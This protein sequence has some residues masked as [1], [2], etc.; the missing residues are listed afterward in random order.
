MPPKNGMRPIHPGELL[1]DELV[2]L[3]TS[4]DEFDEL[5]GLPGGTVAQIVQGTR[6][7]DADFAL[8]IARYL[9]GG[10]RLWMNLQVSYDLKIAQRKSGAAIAKQITPRKDNPPTPQGDY[11]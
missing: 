3:G 1:Q 7:I 9:G 6:N 10:E 2:E 8:R 11:Q 5:L 4:P